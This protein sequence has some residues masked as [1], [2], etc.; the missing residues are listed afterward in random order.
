MK[1]TLNKDGKVKQVQEDAIIIDG[2]EEMKK[3]YVVRLI[4]VTFSGAKICI[5]EEIFDEKPAPNQIMWC[6]KKHDDANFASVVENYKLLED[7]DKL[8]FE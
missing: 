5:A 3:Y 7:T 4:K 6:L 1:Y 2:S 8:P